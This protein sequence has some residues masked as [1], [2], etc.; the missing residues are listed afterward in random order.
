MHNKA[1]LQHQHSTVLEAIWQLERIEI[2][3]HF[4]TTWRK[5]NFHIDSISKKSITKHIID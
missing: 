3:I 2:I 1:L 4:L 5:N